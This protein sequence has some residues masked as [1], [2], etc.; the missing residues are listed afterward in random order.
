MHED[1]PARLCCGQRHWGVICP[2]GQVM[3]ELCYMRY[4][5]ND[6]Y[7]DE[8]RQKWNICIGCELAERGYGFSPLSVAYEEYCRGSE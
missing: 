8:D 3:C 5:Q 1:G 7:V 2:D 6:L 4:A